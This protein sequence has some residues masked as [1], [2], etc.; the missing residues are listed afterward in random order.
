[1]ESD[2]IRMVL[3]RLGL[4]E[5]D[6]LEQT[7]AA[8]AAALSPNHATLVARLLVASLDAHHRS[9]VRRVAHEIG[10]GTGELSA[11][12]DTTGLGPRAR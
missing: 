1:M 8:A 2:P 9:M 5:Y 7:A 12:R 3:G 10:R 6:N 4:F 11:L